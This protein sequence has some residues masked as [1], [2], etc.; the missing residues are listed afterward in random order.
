MTELDLDLDLRFSDSIYDDFESTGEIVLDLG[1]GVEYDVDADGEGD[2]IIQFWETEE[3]YPL[4]LGHDCPDCDTLL[5][6]REEDDEIDFYCP[7][8]H[9]K[10]HGRRIDDY[11]TVVEGRR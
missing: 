9:E 4:E 10:F 2:I 1:D 5:R 11:T 8:C 6:A 7:G 3:A